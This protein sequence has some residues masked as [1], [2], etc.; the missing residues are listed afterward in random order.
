MTNTL[1]PKIASS[2]AL[3]QPT[4]VFFNGRGGTGKTMLARLH[5]EWAL[6]NHVEF[7]IL[8]LD[9]TNATLS[10]FFPDHTDRPPTADDNDV[11]NYLRDAI[12]E[13]T[14]KHHH[15]IIDFGGGD[16]ILKSLASR[17]RL[18]PFF[19]QY[20]IRPVMF[21]HFGADPDYLSFMQYFEKGE[22][23]YPEATVLILNAHVKPARLSV[24]SAFEQTI[25]PHE[26]YKGAK[27]RGAKFVAMPD[28]PCAHQIDRHRLMFYEAYE[29]RD[30]LKPD[31]PPALSPLDRAELG[32]WLEDMENQFAKLSCW[33]PWLP[34]KRGNGS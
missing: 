32:M 26:I 34:A 17:I 24:T 7:R 16:L 1:K 18:V 9:R 3:Q 11:M 14:T 15:L 8:D 28:L 4:T 19:R 30:S 6:H 27:A 22:L 23:F 31:R 33:L 13:Q 25:M 12:N 2:S 10:A 20:N 21:H 5:A 29:G